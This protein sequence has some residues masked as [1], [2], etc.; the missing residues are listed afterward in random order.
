[1]VGAKTNFSRGGFDSE[2][3]KRSLIIVAIKR[4]KQ[5]TD[6]SFESFSKLKLWRAKALKT[7]RKMSKCRKVLG[8]LGGTVFPSASYSFRC[9]QPVINALTR[10]SMTTTSTWMHLT[11]GTPNG[12]T[13]SRNWRVKRPIKLIRPHL[14]PNWLSSAERFKCSNIPQLCALYMHDQCSLRVNFMRTSQR[15]LKGDS[16][17]QHGSTTFRKELCLWHSHDCL[18]DVT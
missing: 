17:L 9:H 4:Q 14:Q 1:M 2:Y 3:S 16:S 13:W 15:L 10:E 12:Q 6:K 5:L 7:L 18:R 11:M 8:A